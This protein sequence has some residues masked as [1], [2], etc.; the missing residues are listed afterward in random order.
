MNLP[1]FCNSAPLDEVRRHGHVL[2]PGRYAGTEPQPQPVSTSRFAWAIP[3][4]VVG[5][6]EW[7]PR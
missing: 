2:T 5:V 1:G 4:T 7:D 6:S 3:P